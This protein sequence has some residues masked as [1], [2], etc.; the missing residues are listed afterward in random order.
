[1]LPLSIRDQGTEV[2]LSARFTSSPFDH[3]QNNVDLPMDYLV[4][5]KFRARESLHAVTQVSQLHAYPLFTVHCSLG[6]AAQLLS[7]V[8]RHFQQK[9]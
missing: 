4:W 1:M 5:L 6:E 3:L 8:A 9:S 7:L 2:R